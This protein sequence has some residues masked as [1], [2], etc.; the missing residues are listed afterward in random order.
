MATFIG[1]IFQETITPSFVSSTVSVDP[2]G[3]RPSNAVG[4]I[5]AGGGGG[6]IDA[7]GG[8]DTV[9]GGDARDWLPAVQ[10]PTALTAAPT[11]IR[12]NT[13]NHPPP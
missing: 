1:T 13:T 7:G 3:S 12:H 8:D 9:F 10:G 5:S 2:A 6:P 4:F 11:W